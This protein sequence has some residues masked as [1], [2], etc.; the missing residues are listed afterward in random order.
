MFVIGLHVFSL[1]S[2]FVY[3]IALR[4][5]SA[6]E[7]YHDTLLVRLKTDFIYPNNSIFSALLY[8]MSVKK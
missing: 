5:D 3:Q 2:M 6:S 8:T 7:P 4:S 1:Q